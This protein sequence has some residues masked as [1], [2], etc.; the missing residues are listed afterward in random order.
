[1]IIGKYVFG[2]VAIPKPFTVL[3]SGKLSTNKNQDTSAGVYHQACVDHDVPVDEELYTHLI[4]RDRRAWSGEVDWIM[5]PDEIAFACAE[6]ANVSRRMRAEGTSMPPRSV[7][8]CRLCDWSR[9]CKT[10]PQGNHASWFGVRPR[11]N[12][13]SGAASSYKLSDRTIDKD[14]SFI[15]SPSQMRG[16][17]ACPRKWYL[18]YKLGLEP[19]KSE[20]RKVS[21]RTYGT[22]VHEGCA[23]LGEAAMKATDLH[24]FRRN[25]LE[26]IARI[27]VEAKVNELKQLLTDED[28]DWR[29]PECTATAVRM[30]ELATESLESVLE[31]EMRRAFVIPGTRSWVTCQPDLIGRDYEGDDVI[32]DYKT[33]SSQHLDTV[34]DD[35]LNH[36][37]MFLYAQAWLN[38]QLVKGA[39]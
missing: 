7:S 23:I 4:A 2:R 15:L 33:S 30:F 39:K 29:I 20:W 1:M 38:G 16:Y 34:A 5:H 25:N 8:S 14:S 18:S 6:A 26:T 36:P 24:T 9:Y 19:A 37:A 3:K 13:Y 31:V 22:L 10:D 28:Q 27:G 12:E 35:Y 21:A 17:M 32:I 11:G